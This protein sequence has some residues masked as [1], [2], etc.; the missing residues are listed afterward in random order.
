MPKGM[1]SERINRRSR[2]LADLDLHSSVGNED[3]KRRTGQ[4]KRKRKKKRIKK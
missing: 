4:Q 2:K 1:K 3:I